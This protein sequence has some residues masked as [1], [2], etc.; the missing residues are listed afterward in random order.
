MKIHI[1][2]GPAIHWIFLACAVVWL[3]PALQGQTVIGSITRPGLRPA[4]VAVFEAGNRVFVFD[5]ATQKIYMFDGVTHAELNS[6]PATPGPDPDL[7]RLPGMVVHEQRGKL[8]ALSSGGILVIDAFTG[9]LIRTLP[10]YISDYWTLKET[11]RLALDSNAGKLYAVSPTAG[12]RQINTLNDSETTV[13][14]AGIL[15]PIAVN[16]VTHEVFGAGPSLRTM[17]IVDGLTLAVTTVPYAAGNLAV[18]WL[19][20]KLYSGWRSNT[21]YDRKTNTVMPIGIGEDQ[22]DATYLGFNPVSNRMYTGMEIDQETTII[23]GPTNS[24][25]NLPLRDTAYPPPVVR[26]STNHVYFPGGTSTIVVDDTSQM[27]KKVPVD[28]L[29]KGGEYFYQAIAINQ[30][31]GRVYVV[32]HQQTG[33][34]AVLQDT[35]WRCSA[36]ISPTSASLRGD[37][38]GVGVKVSV[39]TSPECSWSV[40]TIAPAGIEGGSILFDMGSGSSSGYTGSGVASIHAWS[41]TTL[42]PRTGSVKIAGQLFTVSQ[43]PLCAYSSSISPSMQGFGPEG[44]TGSVSVSATAGCNWSATSSADWIKITSGGSGTGSGTLRYVAAANPAMTD[45]DATVSIAEQSFT[46]V[47]TGVGPP[48]MNAYGIGNAVDGG[49]SAPGGLI[50]IFGGNLAPGMA[51]APGTPLP[52]SLLGTT[53]EM[54]SGERRWQLPLLFVSLRQINAQLPF[55]AGDTAE[56]RI[57]TA[58]GSSPPASLSISRVAPRIFVNPDS[59]YAALHADYQMVSEAN[60]A[61]PGEVVA[62]YLTGMGAVSPPLA[63]GA[64]GGDGTP[65]R[66][67]N[68]VTTAVDVELFGVGGSVPASV[69]FA[70]VAPGYAGLY[71]VNIKVPP[72][73]SPGRYSVTVTQSFQRSGVHGSLPVGR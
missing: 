63:P 45:R 41:N 59:I 34:V 40:A 26:L 23:D 54:S 32:N 5:D 43:A 35:P 30:T 37:N 38:S 50:S 67:L 62:L 58:T 14:G 66:P 28:K 12:L 72:S 73:L 19:E 31:T 39:T 47:Q 56:I 71:Q 55:D 60:P 27:F 36:S 53:V 51:A 16:P 8:Y 24:T 17:T 33:S 6:I 20:N 11:P 13:P 25:W 65:D 15:C 4:E 61:K 64:A 69:E 21:I 18:N 1:K 46:V 10:G 48:S 29:F 57:S 22:N 42:N 49:G 2:R 70:G 68:R 52:T 9:A 3:E 7:P 44:G